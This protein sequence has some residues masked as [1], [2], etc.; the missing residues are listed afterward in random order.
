MTTDRQFVSSTNATGYA[1]VAVSSSG[2]ND[3][4][5]PERSLEVKVK[6]LGETIATLR[7]LVAGSD[8]YNRQRAEHRSEPELMPI[9]NSIGI[10]APGGV[11][12][13]ERTASCMAA[14]NRETSMPI[15]SSI[16]ESQ[17][18]E[19]EAKKHNPGHSH[20]RQQA[21]DH[22]TD[23]MPIQNSLGITLD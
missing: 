5:E 3:D 17:T 14:T 11:N 4:P 23:P 9:Q 7:E 16:L 2:Q 20:G 21:N 1:G 22:D 10:D 13:R 6:Q 18:A 15:R 8:T 19:T 12:R